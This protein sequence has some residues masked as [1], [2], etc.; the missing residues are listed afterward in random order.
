VMNTGDGVDTLVGILAHDADLKCQER[1]VGIL[2]AMA[3]HGYSYR[4][5]M[6]RKRAIPALLELSLLGSA[7]AQKRAVRVLELLRDDRE[8]HHQLRRNERLANITN[9]AL[10]CSVKGERTLRTLS[11]CSRFSLPF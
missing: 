7:A 9:P 8:Q 5:A 6:V 11:L 2:L 3:H 4:Q 10:D 1:A